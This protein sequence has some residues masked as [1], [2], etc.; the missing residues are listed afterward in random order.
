MPRRWKA[1]IAAIAVI[2]SAYFGID[3]S[4][5]VKA[6]TLQQPQTIEGQLHESEAN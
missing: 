2:V 3:I 1:V 6:V 5:V 4:N